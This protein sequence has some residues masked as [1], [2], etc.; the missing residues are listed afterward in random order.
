[1]SVLAYVE[2]SKDGSVTKDLSSTGVTGRRLGKGCYELRGLLSDRCTIMAQ[3]KPLSV[4]DCATLCVSPHPGKKTF[5]AYAVVTLDALRIDGDGRL[6]W[7]KMTEA[8][9]A[10]F[11]LIVF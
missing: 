9:D 2:V 5:Y 8:V 10:D 1:V 3:P 7:L 11:S 4:E 6:R